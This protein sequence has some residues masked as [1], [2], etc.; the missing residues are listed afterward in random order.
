[1][2]FTLGPRQQ[3]WLQALKSGNYTQTTGKLCMVGRDSQAPSFCCLGVLCDVEGL[4][5]SLCG[6]G[7]LYNDFRRYKFCGETSDNYLPREF[8]YELGLRSASGEIKTDLL[9]EDLLE[10]LQYRRSL[11]RVN[12]NLGV[13]AWPLIIEIME[14]CPEALFSK[15]V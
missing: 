11:S 4:D 3:R 13:H 7:R 2:P 8:A 5:F 12:D 10:R 6:M 15:S 9:P 14:R 1:M